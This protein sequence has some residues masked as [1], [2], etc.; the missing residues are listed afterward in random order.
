MD[1]AIVRYR[2]LGDSGMLVSELS[3]GAMTFGEGMGS[4][5]KVDQGGA[6]AMV[7][8]AL[9]AGVNLFD[10]ANVYAGGQS[11]QMLGKALAAHRD[12]VLIATKV[13]FQSAPRTTEGPLSYRA[14]VNQCEASLRRL[15]TDWIDLYQVHRPDPYTPTEETLRA[16]DDLVRR[17][18]VRYVG[19]C[20]L[21]TWEAARAVT[22]Q[23]ERGLVPYVS[24]Q[25]Y[26]SL[27]GRDIEEELVPLCEQVGIGILPWSPLAGGFLTG[28]YT[29]EQAAPEDR[30]AT[31]DF[32][33][34]DRERGDAVIEIAREIA[35]D[36]RASPAQVALAWL[37][38]KPWVSSVIVGASTTEQ[39]NENLAAGEVDLAA[40]EVT[41]LDEASALPSRYPH[42]WGRFF[43]EPSLDR[44]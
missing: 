11:E 34:V 5:T 25:M 17:G 9:E 35:A 44:G 40:D 7:G 37:L 13:G 19:F 12:E 23:R 31:F 15:G 24:A 32:P 41:R 21:A 29:G 36:H 26:Y 18:L 6:D 10:T 33:P 4:I 43:A 42:W 2:R 8:A 39:L 27:V 28:K 1:G 3:L 16:F 30:R 20:N 14:I 22:L 38:A